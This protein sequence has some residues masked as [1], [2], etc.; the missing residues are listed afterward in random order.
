MNCTSTS[1]KPK[2]KKRSKSK[3]DK[4]QEKVVINIPRKK[5]VKKEEAEETVPEVEV[6]DIDKIVNPPN[7]KFEHSTLPNVKVELNENGQE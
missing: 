5:K 3:K 2:K 7:L 6:I 1:K 4:K